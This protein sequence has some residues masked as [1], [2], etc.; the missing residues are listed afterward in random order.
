MQPIENIV[1][2]TIDRETKVVSQAG[3]GVPLIAG[4]HTLF[5]ERIKFFN[6][7]TVLTEL[8]ALGFLASS[9]IYLQA[10]AIVAQSPRVERL[11]IGK[12]DTN[13]AGVIEVQFSL[14]FVSGNVINM[15]VNGTPISPV[16]YITSQT[17]TMDLLETAI[18]AIPNVVAAT[19]TGSMIS[20]QFALGAIA[21]IA[22]VEVIGGSTQPTVVINVLTPAVTVSTGLAAIAN[23][24]E[25]FYGVCLESNLF[26]DQL[27]A[28][29][30]IESHGTQKL[31][32]FR[33]AVSTAL[34]NATTD[35]GSVLKAKNFERSFVSY[36][37]IANE[38][39]D[40]AILGKGLAEEPGSITYKFKVLKG[41]TADN[42]TAGALTNLQ[43]KNINH[44][45]ATGG[46]SILQEGK[47]AAG[48]FIDVISGVDW[49]KTRMQEGVFG[50]LANA[51]KIPY[52]DAGAKILETE[53][54]NILQ[55]AVAR[56]ILAEFPTFTVFIPKVATQTTPDKLARFFPGI[57]WDAT[58][59]G[60]IHKVRINGTVSV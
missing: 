24:S 23:E 59:A 39:I 56:T 13:V 9:A 25:D 5:P 28:A 26:N 16:T 50:V 4:V 27:S 33:T 31:G 43:F 54:K 37:N 49:I 17:A 30:W 19:A 47:V 29:E 20:V 8:L 35:I 3:F 15:D 52:T 58:L 36:H 45:V 57:T 40:A 7:L 21:T 2:V 14:N 6:G 22:N 60:A 44:V 53:I 51:K 10:Q 1:N 46:I 42:L 12:L 48:E 11:A 38:Y 34:S 18:E 32:S 55:Q 41:I